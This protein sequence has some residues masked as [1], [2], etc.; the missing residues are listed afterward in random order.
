MASKSRSTFSEFEKSTNQ[1][2][3][4]LLAAGALP[5]DRIGIWSTNHV[6]WIQTQFAAAKAGIILVNINPSYKSAELAFVLKMCEIKGLISDTIYG[7]Q[8]YENILQKAVSDHGSDLKLEFV[9]YRGDNFTQLNGIRTF[10][11]DNLYDGG[12]T[13]FVTQ[14]EEIISKAQ[15]DDPVNIQFTSGT[16]GLPKGA[17]LTHHNILNNAFSSG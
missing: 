11:F 17:T 10:S 6:E 3:A 7:Q 2:A 8:N 12:D 1:I 13:N 16:T 5:G 9:A 4:S 14:V 15:M